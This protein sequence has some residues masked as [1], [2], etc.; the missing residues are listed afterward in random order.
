MAAPEKFS[1]RAQVREGTVFV[2]LTVPAELAPVSEVEPSPSSAETLAT[3]HGPRF[4]Y[5]RWRGK[6]YCFGPKQRR[7]IAALWKAHQQGAEWVL[8]DV[9][10]DLADSD[11]TRVRDLFKGHPA[12]DTLIV[13]PDDGPPGSYALAPD[14]CQ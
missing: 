14:V 10:L 11:G 6:V 12:W 8:Q 9:L 7:I 2:T 13:Q 1:A 5:V 4:E 3:K